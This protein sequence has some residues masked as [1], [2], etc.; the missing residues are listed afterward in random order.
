MNRSKTLSFFSALLLASF[1]LAAC[2]GPKGAV[3]TV[4]CGGG[5]GGNANLS[6]TLLD[7]PPTNTTF[8]NFN[9][10]VSL[11]SL[12]PQS[13]ADVNVLSTP[14]TYEITRLQSD[15]TDIGTFQIPAGT[16]TKLNFF[17][18]GNAPTS[19]WIN[20]SNATING[21]LP[22]QVCHLAGTSQGQI[23][24]D[25]VKALGGQGLVL[26]SGQNIGL[27]V[28]FNLNNAITAVNGISIDLTQ[29]S[30]FNV[31]KLPRTGQ[32]S[33]TLDTIE[34][35]TGVVTTV[36]GNNITLK[37]D[38]GATLTVVSG[39]ATTFNAPPG[40][41]TACGGNFNL[42]CVKVGQTLSVD[43]TVALNGSLALTNVDFLDLPAVNEIEGTIFNTTTA[44]TYLL[45]V[46]D[47]TLVGT[48]AILQTI[49]SST[50]L[51]LTLDPAT[52]FAVETSD[53]PVANPAGFLSA[54]DILNGQ[55]VLARV[56]S[57]TSTT[58]INVVADRLILR[59]S[60]FTG[61]V[62]TVS[63]PVFTIQNLPSYIGFTLAPQVQTYVPQTTFDGVADITGLNGLTTPVSIRALFLNPAT[64]Q[65][66]LLAAKV[67]KH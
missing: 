36:S 35:F 10:P 26:T 11:V 29:S 20:A 17:V 22:L 44:G 65:P 7:A 51:N 31:I 1:S 3:C 60:R 6:L 14:T 25:L 43:A 23:S 39:S 9:L 66:P 54:G 4:G 42:A 59:F 62:G 21:C 16:Y 37:A 46:S 2:S 48:N 28:E 64:A 63:G 41:S 13:G 18:T 67:R 32:P 12:T 58:S 5:G 52:T 45:V 19:V 57:E 38:S 27:G 8:I 50:T 55:T 40:G 47:K 33:N 56:K 30:V 24:V 15:S 49:G 61:T 53:L 34:A